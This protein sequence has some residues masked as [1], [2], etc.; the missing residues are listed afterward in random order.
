MMDGKGKYTAIVGNVKEEVLEGTF[1][2]N[3]KNGKCK[4]TTERKELSQKD[5]EGG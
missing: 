4:V 2:N 1:K 3:K 5:E